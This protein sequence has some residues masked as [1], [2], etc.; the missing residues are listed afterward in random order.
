MGVY[1]LYSSTNKIADKW[2]VNYDPTES[3]FEPVSEKVLKEKV[4][5]NN[6][7]FLKNERQIINDVQKTRYGRELWKYLIA[8]V[9]LLLFV[10]MI[11]A[12]ER[13]S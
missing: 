1:S 5:S 13:S 6:I 10:E 12:R 7:T 3:D 2:I 8:A 9:L 4:G 11:I